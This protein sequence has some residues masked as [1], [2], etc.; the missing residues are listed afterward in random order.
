MKDSKLFTGSICV[1]DLLEQ[2]RK[3]HSAFVKSPTNDK[4]YCNILLWENS[5]T[6]KFGNS[7]SIQLN[8]TKDMK[9]TEA[10]VYIG[11][12]KPMERKEPKPLTAEQAK[13]F[14]DE[15][16]NDLPF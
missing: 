15:V 9:E 5:E 16:P 10:R 2:M 6:D 3:P 8:S 7:H 11:N 13:T 14:I 4:V 12:A 1:S